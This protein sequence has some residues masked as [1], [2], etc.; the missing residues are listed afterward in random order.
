V[1]GCTQVCFWPFSSVQ[2]IWC[3]VGYQGQPD[4]AR[5][6]QSDED[7]PLQTSSY[8][9]RLR[10]V[11]AWRGV[12]DTVDGTFR[13]AHPSNPAVDNG[14][15]MPYLPIRD[16]DIWFDRAGTGSAL[17]AISG[18]RGDLRRKPNLLES[19]L[20]RAFDL[21][22]YDQ[23]GLGRTSK[24]DKPYSMADYADD[25]AALMDAVGWEC[26]RVVGL[27]FGGMVALELAL[28]HP[29]RVTKLV[30][31]CTSPGGA[32]GSS[33][34]LHTLQ[35]L[36]SDERAQRMV[37]I[38]DTRC[39]AGWAAENPMRMQELLKSSMDDAF[40]DEPGHQTGITRV[41][42]AR[43]EHDTWERLNRIACSVLI[44]GGRYDGIALPAS[45]Q[46]M[47]NRIPGATLRM[48]EGGHLFLWQDYSAFPEIIEFLR[49]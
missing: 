19:P 4:S 47:A 11:E 24:P 22:G 9:D 6:C 12:V 7:D 39:H 21:V 37:S 33:Y 40:A 15:L 10:P 16:I 25:A 8:T 46:R 42:E 3:F 28:R 32:G 34:P 38:S 13:L 17:L 20:A 23:R 26:G 27:S 30:L 48:F 29:Q 1:A 5:H 45:Q 36:P 44:C 43:R 31:C 2:L 41:L 18:S 49:E 35:A 14:F